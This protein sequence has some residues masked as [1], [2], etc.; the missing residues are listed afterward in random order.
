MRI[1]KTFALCCLLTVPVLFDCRCD[2]ADEDS[3]YLGC[4]CENGDLGHCFD[5]TCSCD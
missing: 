3:Y 5:G 1:L 4:T 2:C